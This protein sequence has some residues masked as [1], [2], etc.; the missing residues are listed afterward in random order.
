MRVDKR[1]K[2]RLTVLL[3]LSSAFWLVLLGAPALAHSQLLQADPASGATL[4][5]PPTQVRLQFNEPVELAFTPVKVSDEQGNR[6]DEDDARIDPE[7][8]RVVLTTLKKLP[9]GSYT[10]EWRVIS[11][12]THPVNGTYKF[13]VIGAGT[14]ESQGA[15]Q[16]QAGGSNDPSSDQ[17]EPEPGGQQDTGG[18]GP[19]LLHLAALGLGAVVVIVLLLWQRIKGKRSS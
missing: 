16:A 2:R 8:K 7:D 18:V 17:S 1:R 10:V 13:D 11:A 12:D 19:H 9:I 5:Q 3:G 14:T 4:S 15:A 6:V